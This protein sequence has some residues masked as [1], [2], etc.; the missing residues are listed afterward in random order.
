[1]TLSPQLQNLISEIM[2]EG[3]AEL[4]ARHRKQELIA[5]WNLNTIS[6]KLPD[7]DIASISSFSHLDREKIIDAIAA[8]EATLNALGDDESGQATNLIKLKG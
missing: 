6:T 8:F 7:E 2:V 3:A 4:Q 1:M 5:R